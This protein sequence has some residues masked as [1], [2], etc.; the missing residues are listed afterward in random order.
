VSIAELAPLDAFEMLDVFRVIDVREDHEFRGPLG[1][2]EIAESIPLA[3]VGKYAEKLRGSR[4]LLLVC[5]SG[6]RSG[7]ACERLAKLGC[8]YTT[9]LAGG[10]I[11][12]NGAALPV[13]HSEPKT[14]GGLVDQVVSWTTQVGPLDGD[15][16]R[17]IVRNR[18]EAH[19]VS[20]D[21]PN[22]KAVED[23]ITH[24]T[25]LLG[26]TNPPDLE[27]SVAFFRR[28]LAVL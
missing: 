21:K 14:L 16:V 11:A 7:I 18:F 23:V 22:H 25:D 8:E 6:K 1:C 4:P 17:D 19:S 9:N 5:R 24:V 2:I 3:T 12:W 28:S 10:M 15:S 26:A 27:L 20:S 13:R